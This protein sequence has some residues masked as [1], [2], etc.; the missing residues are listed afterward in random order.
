MAY[1]K[2]IAN[3]GLQRFGRRY[4]CSYH[5]V[6]IGKWIFKMQEDLAISAHTADYNTRAIGLMLCRTDDEEFNKLT[7]YTARLKFIELH[8]EHEFVL[9]VFHSDVSKIGKP[10]PQEFKPWIIM[11]GMRFDGR[12]EAK[13][14]NIPLRKPDLRWKQI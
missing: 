5:Y 10:D 13:R 12:D 4:G 11:L 2:I 6:I 3:T 7:M 9:A 14:L 1:A 8:E